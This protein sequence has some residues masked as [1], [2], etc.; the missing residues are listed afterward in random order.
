VAHSRPRGTDADASAAADRLSTAF[1]GALLAGVAAVCLVSAPLAR[2][3]L[4]RAGHHP[5]ATAL[6]EAGWRYGIGAWEWLRGALFTAVLAAC[7]VL[8]LTPLVALAAAAAP[9]VALRWRAKAARH[10]ASVA[11]TQLLRASE[12][13]LRAGAAMPEALRRATDGSADRL[14]RRPFVDALRAF[15][16]RAS[17]DEA[18]RAAAPLAVDRATRGAI[19]TLALGVGSRLSH[20]RTAALVAA[21]ADRLA[22][23][24]RLAEEVRA[25]TT[26]LRSQILLLALIVP[27]L[28]AYLA[29]TVPSLGDTLATPLGR[30]VLLPLAAALELIG[31]VI[32]RRAVDEAVR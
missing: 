31:F 16:L 23:E 27:A 26:G 4:P 20:E 13:A 9:S 6:E 17:L 12:A 14:A 3:S 29:L 25:K 2:R 18:L 22:F 7:I 8:S 19:E 30:F 28:C 21:A 24:R 1:A 10:R 5:D 15:D 11:T 32:S